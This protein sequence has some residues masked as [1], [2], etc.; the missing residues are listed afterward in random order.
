M[1]LARFFFCCCLSFFLPPQ[2][3]KLACMVL[4]SVFAGSLC[5]YFCPADDMGYIM[6][7]K[8]SW[9]KV[10][11]RTVLAIDRFRAAF[12]GEQRVAPTLSEGRYRTGVMRDGCEPTLELGNTH[13]VQPWRHSEIRFVLPMVLAVNGLLVC[14]TS[15]DFVGACWIPTTGEFDP[16][17]FWARTASM[18]SIRFQPTEL[19]PRGYVRISFSRKHELSCVCLCAFVFLVSLGSLA[20]DDMIHP[21]DR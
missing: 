20:C 3:P 2:I 13:T 19:V 11:V 8:N 21:R 16:V 15:S 17:C 18:R 7:S 14:P 1:L 6:T 10:S 12:G 5:R 4:V 9:F